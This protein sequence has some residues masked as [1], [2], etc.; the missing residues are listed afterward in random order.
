MKKPV[1]L[2]WTKY[3]LPMHPVVYISSISDDRI[4]NIGAFATCVDVSYSPP[5]VSFASAKIQHSSFGHQLHQ[6]LGPQD[7]YL[8]IKGNNKFIVN[9]PGV[10]L[11]TTLNIV[12]YPLHTTVDEFEIARLTKRECFY[13]TNYESSPK[14]ILECLV[15]LECELVQIVDIP[16]CDHF[17]IFGEVKFCSIDETLGT[18]LTE[19]REK[20]IDQVF[21][22]L[23]AAS[24][25]TRYIGTIV[26]RE[27][28]CPV[29]KTD[30]EII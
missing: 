7:T 15:H 22:N 13:F 10:S 3:L 25:T 28:E 20:L 29:F 23:R 8:N 24:N 1:P 17:I 2:S 27:I 16:I 9:V 4:D 30:S 19:V 6:Q 11:S 14:I 12:G 26:K 18:S 21:G 5:I